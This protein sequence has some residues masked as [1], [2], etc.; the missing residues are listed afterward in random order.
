MD[1]IVRQA[2][3]KWPNVPHCF[4]WLR[5]DARGGWRMRD[6]RAQHLGLPGDRIAHPAL[7]AFIERN[8][9]AD[10]TG[11]W[12]FQNGPQR[13]Y[14]DLELMPYIVRTQPGANGH[15]ELV[16]HTGQRMDKIDA[17]WLDQHGRLYLK[18]G[19]K[20]GALDDRDMAHM[21][22]ALRVD[23]SADEDAL[24][25]WMEGGNPGAVLK[26]EH[27]GRALTVQRLDANELARHFGFVA[28]PRPE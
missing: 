5:L 6:E 23:G 7:L 8:Y 10:E 19:E 12:Y 16:L 22:G 20:A 9:A 18:E 4:G 3:A 13:V 11:R 27:A 17:A 15:P 21:L 25:R 24:L 14:V 26:L 28:M 1:E 2:M